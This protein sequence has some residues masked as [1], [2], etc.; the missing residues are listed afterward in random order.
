M[1]VGTNATL[2]IDSVIDQL[3]VLSRFDGQE[4]ARSVASYYLDADSHP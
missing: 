1:F 3:N 2:E 4:D